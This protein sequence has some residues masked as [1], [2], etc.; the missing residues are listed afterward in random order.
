MLSVSF[1]GC[2]SD[3]WGDAQ[4]IGVEDRLY[5]NFRR[6]NEQPTFN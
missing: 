6:L 3:H 5:F 2:S 1:N 4:V